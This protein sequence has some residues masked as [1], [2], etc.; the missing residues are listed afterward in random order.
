MRCKPETDFGHHCTKTD[1][2][3]VFKEALALA[4]TT[5]PHP[6]VG[7]ARLELVKAQTPNQDPSRCVLRII[8]QHA[9]LAQGVVSEQHVTKWRIISRMLCTHSLSHADVATMQR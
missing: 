5:T 2:R 6:C 8:Y 1:I 9:G 4:L 3:F 7:R